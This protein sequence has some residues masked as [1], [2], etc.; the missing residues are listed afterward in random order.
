MQGAESFASFQVPALQVTTW[1]H[2]GSASDSQGRQASHISQ[3]RSSAGNE[4][5]ALLISCLSSSARSVGANDW[6]PT[7]LWS[8]AVQQ[9]EGDPAD[10]PQVTLNR[11]SHEFR[12]QQLE[13]GISGQSISSGVRD[14]K[15]AKHIAKQIISAG[16]RS[17]N[18]V[19]DAGAA[20]DDRSINRDILGT[21]ERILG[22]RLSSASFSGHPTSSKSGLNSR[23]LTKGQKDR[24][25]QQSRTHFSN[26]L[27]EESPGSSQKGHSQRRGQPGSSK[28]HDLEIALR[29]PFKGTGNPQAPL[30][31]RQP[32][33]QTESKH[34]ATEADL[35]KAS[36]PQT[37]AKHLQSGQEA[38]SQDSQPAQPGL[39]SPAP[40]P[41]SL[42]MKS[43]MDVRIQPSSAGQSPCQEESGL[44]HDRK[45]RGTKN[46]WKRVE[47]AR[48]RAA[49]KRTNSFDGH[50]LY[51]NDRCAVRHILLVLPVSCLTRESIIG[52]PFS[53]PRLRGALTM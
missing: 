22:E 51:Q 36:K 30:D 25:L 53:F 5:A 2:T 28:T 29:T 11:T 12:S 1:S 26:L 44:T 27:Y 31:P 49:L 18:S 33:E 3:P 24:M 23:E 9:V 21:R 20:A 8:R 16:R 10:N 32:N 19:S 52:D 41:T 38:E 34:A 17:H 35:W 46:W 14:G 37:V 43:W 7:E 45:N 13:S 50:A 40:S 42:K 39:E 4:N 48:E 6:P 47:A 15:I